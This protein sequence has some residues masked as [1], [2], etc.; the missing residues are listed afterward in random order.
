MTRTP[1]LDE[2]QVEEL[3]GPEDEI[4]EVLF[5]LHDNW[6]KYRGHAV[7]TI[8]SEFMKELRRGR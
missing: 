1:F 6:P 7:P 2:E 4:E 5:E 8:L 3:S